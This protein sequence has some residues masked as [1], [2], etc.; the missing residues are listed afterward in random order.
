MLL[1]A[2]EAMNTTHIFCK[3]QYKLSRWLFNQYTQRSNACYGEEVVTR[4]L[5]YFIVILEISNDINVCVLDN[6]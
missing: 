3:M 6:Y 5:G 4:N 1:G 2:L